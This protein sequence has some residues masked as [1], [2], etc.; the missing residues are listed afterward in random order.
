MSQ[1]TNVVSSRLQKW[2][3]VAALVSLVV[4]AEA[5]IEKTG[6]GV[7]VTM[8][9]FL[10]AMPPKLTRTERLPKG[11]HNSVEVALVAHY[12]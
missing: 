7:E 9:T 3:V 10:F 11:D 2:V 5:L 6:L 1:T 8:L 12:V 4:L